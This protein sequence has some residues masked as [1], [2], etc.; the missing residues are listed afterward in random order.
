MSCLDLCTRPN[1][2][3]A[4]GGAGWRCL[5]RA[6]IVLSVSLTAASFGVTASNAQ[7]VISGPPIDSNG[8]T[9]FT[10]SSDSQVIY[11]SSSTG[12][13]SNS[14]LSA[15]APVK[16]IRRGTSLLRNGY[17]DWLLLKKGDSWTLTSNG[18]QFNTSGYPGSLCLSGRSATEPMLIASYG[19]GARPL[20]QT[21]LPIDAQNQYFVI[22]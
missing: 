4:A 20:L 5:T 6:L 10:P 13:D 2:V 11:V 22:G 19:T 8:W 15:S 12:N 3:L 18:D 14:G 1:R 7:T 21:D 9:V 16:T 17:P